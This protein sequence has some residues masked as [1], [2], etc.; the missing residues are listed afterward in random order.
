[1][2]D[3][4]P[5]PPAET[6]LHLDGI[7]AVPLL[8]LAEPDGDAVTLARDTATDALL[9]L[10]TYDSSGARTWVRISDEQA[11]QLIEATRAALASK[12]R[13]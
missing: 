9:I 6:L 1:M 12:A 5:R 2:N 3:H 11:A 13:R 4:Q 10:V 7:E 8:R